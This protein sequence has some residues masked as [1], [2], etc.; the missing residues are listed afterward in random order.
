MLN[1]QTAAT[2]GAWF[3]ARADLQRLLD[4]LREDGRRV[5]GPTVRDGAI[6]C[7]EI[8]DVG[9]LP[10]G[11]GDDQS[12][13]RYRLVQQAHERLFA[14]VVGPTSWKRY[15]YPPRV[16]QT[17]ARYGDGGSV[18]YASVPSDASPMAFLGVRACELAA[19]RVQDRVFLGAPFVE[20]DYQQRR[21]AALV[22]AVQCTASASTCF[23]TS[24]ECG[25]EVKAGAG[26]DLAMTEI[27]E[28][29]VVEAGTPQ[30]SELLARLPVTAATMNQAVAVVQAVAANRAR[31]GQRLQTAGL[32]DRLLAQMDH[33]RWAEI[34]ARCISCGNC[35]SVCPT[36]FCSS[37]ERVTDLAAREATSVR[38]WDSCFSPGF[39]KV[40]GGDARPQ[41]RHRYR[42]WLTHKFATWW[43][44]FATSGCTGCGRCITF[45]P[46]G[47]DVREEL[48]AI[49]PATPKPAPPK[50]EP[51]AD[52]RQAYVSAR[53]IGKRAETPDTTTL[54]LSGLDGSH[55]DG[56]PGQFVM[57]GLPDHPPAAISVSRYRA[58]DGLE[59]T[60]RGAGPATKAIIAL[61]VG[62]SVGI[63]GPVGTGWPIDVAHGKD[64]VV[65]T[66]GTGL[67]PLRPLLDRLIAER[68][69][70]GDIRLYYGAPDAR[71]VLYADE[72]ER[73]DRERTFDVTC[74]WLKRH[75]DAPGAGSGRST[76][77]AIHQ[78]SWDGSNAV[79]YV[80]GPERMMEATA[81]ALAG[82]GV[83]RD[84]VWVTLERHM[85]C[86][87]GF[88]GHCQLGRF[89]VC[90]DGP[91]F[92]L[93]ELGHLFGREGV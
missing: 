46:V 35:T 6:V 10:K 81:I 19:L 1:A 11:I 24:M 49:A 47:I 64:V 76:V 80:C 88:C 50:F 93:S 41:T 83:K 32:R 13:G 17:K 15:T 77:S 78:A 31:I 72:L 12:P 87:L 44:Q 52:E 55:T 70:F 63:R 89:F 84:N 36:C 66:G 74:R 75:L 7:E 85:E 65:V 8:A 20:T 53:I 29:F 4:R 43:D 26:H 37:I 3:L 71:A 5:I 14:H 16:P 92:R 67:A 28:G 54:V 90:R 61:P 23:C 40:V 33:P 58:P 39:T 27:D 60:I 2:G 86:G 82:R 56:Q 18:D 25:P 38:I 30:G 73:W 59:L 69:R 22:I 79:A 51:V 34:A 21:R 57:V 45:C 62:A 9:E 91:V 48:D 42:Q 68:A